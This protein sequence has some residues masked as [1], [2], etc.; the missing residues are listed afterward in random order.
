MLTVEGFTK[1]D[2][3]VSLRH[4]LRDGGGES[5]VASYLFLWSNTIGDML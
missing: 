4:F 5:K 3:L 1:P 2:D